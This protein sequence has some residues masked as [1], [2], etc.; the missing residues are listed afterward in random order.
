MD[1]SPTH[2]Y[3][4]AGTYSVTLSV[5][6]PGG[7]DSEKKSVTVTEPQVMLTAAFDIEDLSVVRQNQA[8]RFLDQSTGT[9]PL[10]YMWDFG[11][12]SA[13]TD[14]NPA[15]TYK[16]E[17]V[18]SVTLTVSNSLGSN[19]VMRE[20]MVTPPNPLKANFMAVN[21][22]GAIPLAVQFTDD[23]SSSVS[24]PSYPVIDSWLWDFGDGSTSTEQNPPHIY[25]TEGTY[26][27]TLTVSNGVDSATK[28]KVDFI[29]AAGSTAE[30]KRIPS[31]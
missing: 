26:S 20:I 7:V 25:E 13:S 8:A 19:M 12:G 18:Y 29:N 27:V 4:A 21:K 14:Q 5:T 17:G 28:T 11:D 15:H 3:A 6:G 10:T 24:Y 1:S 30:N 22:G 16:K 23:S 9:A 31:R 2:E